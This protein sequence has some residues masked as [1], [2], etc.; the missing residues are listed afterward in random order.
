[1]KQYAYQYKYDERNRCIWKKLPGC[2]PVYYVYDKADR[3]IFTQDGEQRL[4]GEWT[5]NKYD[6]FG[7]LIISG[8]HKTNDSHS[9]LI[10]KCKDIVVKEQDAAHGYGYSW[11]SLPADIKSTEAIV[12]VV[13]YYDNYDHLLRQS[14]FRQTLDYTEAES[15]GKRYI[16]E[17]L[18]ERTPKGLLTATRIR[19][20]NS[21]GQPN[22]EL[23]T[24]MYHDQRGRVIQTKSTNHL[25]GV[26]TELVDYN[27]TG[28]PVKKLHIHTLKDGVGK[29]EELYTYTYDHAGRLIETKHKWNNNAEVS[30]AR[31]EY[32][33]LGR[34]KKK[35]N[36]NN[37]KLTGEYTYN[38]R[39]WLS[40]IREHHYHQDMS[41]SYAGNITMKQWILNGYRGKYNYSYDNLSRLLKANYTAVTGNQNYTTSYTYDKHGNITTL[42]RYGKLTGGNAV[43]DYG[44]MDDLKL[45]YTGNQ[46]KWV[47]DAGLNVSIDGSMDFKDKN[48]PQGTEEY[49]FNANG[50]MT[51]DLN[52]GITEIKYNLLNLPMEI[53]VDNGTTQGTNRYLYTASG[54]KLRMESQSTPVSQSM[55]IG[56]TL[57]NTYAA[58]NKTKTD[59]VGNKIYENDRLK[60]IQVDGGYIEG[61]AY[62]FY[63]DDHLGNNVGVAKGDGT[64]VQKTHYYPFGMSFADGDGSH[65]Q[66][67]KFGDKELDRSH[68]LNMYD[69]SARHYMPD[70]PRFTTI[71]PMA[72]KYYSI[73]PYAYCLNNPLKY[74]DPD[75]KFPLLGG[76]SPLLGV[77]DVVIPAQTSSSIGTALALSRS[78]VTRLPLTRVSR[79]TSN[80]VKSSPITSESISAMNKTDVKVGYANQK[81]ND[82]VLEAEKNEKEVNHKKNMDKNAPDGKGTAKRTLKELINS[83]ET[84]AI[85]AGAVLGAAIIP[86]IAMEMT[87]PNPSKDAY[88]ANLEKLQKKRQEEKESDKDNNS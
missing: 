15:Y 38:V 42:K 69:F 61:G 29:Q 35:V 23:V 26:D 57:G 72:E 10:G 24:A 37:A 68:G 51:K 60:R 30:L 19:R 88:E 71:D 32:D 54:V 76:G 86:K 46:L 34:L 5:F 28:Q 2:E 84:S 13:N 16:N 21:Y 12:L 53:H 87:N 6:A 43:T 33:E 75:G 62:H 74:I 58:T 56:M 55:P 70:I 78:S 20:I 27:F 40:K 82:K 49:A 59:Y 41:Y 25:G 8:I 81:N 80:V 66:P 7:R 85:I 79:V 67:Y 14:N 63:I 31:N 22:G 1:M 65:L 64:L 4:K 48:T 47:S 50:A 3:L 73:S 77:S 39:S 17:G 45:E 36:N 52:K 44:L 9:T 11:S 18:G 83:G